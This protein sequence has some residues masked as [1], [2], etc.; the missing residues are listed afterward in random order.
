[1][2][3]FALAMS[4]ILNA[5]GFGG[6]GTFR[7]HLERVAT[8]REII[9]RLRITAYVFEFVRFWG[10][11]AVCVTHLMVRSLVSKVPPEWEQKF[12]TKRLRN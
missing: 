9:R 12:A 8:R 5:R 2:R 4:P 6:T 10:W 3:S 11:L 1:M 7:N